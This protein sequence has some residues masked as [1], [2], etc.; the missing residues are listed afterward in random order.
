M[1]IAVYGDSFAEPVQFGYKGF[2]FLWCNTLADKLNGSITNFAK[3]GTSIFYSYQKFLDT[4][5]D[6][7]LCIFVTTEPNRYYKSLG[8]SSGTSYHVGNIDQL[9]FYRKRLNLSSEDKQ[10]F[11]WL[12][13]W[14]LSSDKAYNK[15][16]SRLMI[17]DIINKKSNTLVYPSFTESS[18][19]TKLIPFQEMHKMQLA[20]LGKTLNDDLSFL[21]SENPN[22]IAGHF[23][24]TYNN[25]ISEIMYKKI[26][27]GVYDF[28]GLCDITVD[29]TIDY[30]NYTDK[31]KKSPT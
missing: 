31:T 7:D 26:K 3:S 28:F 30:Y 27:H 19:D 12:E 5:N 14:F 13:G 23:T 25:F 21:Y 20:Q 15:C 1:K 11:T 18:H 4:Y 29:T 2:D 8:L 17:N 16:V 10:L 22:K 6:Y 9:E 24:E